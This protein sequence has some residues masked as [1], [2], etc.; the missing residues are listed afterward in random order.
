MSDEKPTVRVVVVDDQ[1]VVR[2]GLVTVLDMFADIDVVGAAANGEQAITLVERH[3]PHVVLMDL[4]MPRSDGVEATAQITRTYPT[5]K[6]VVLT[7][8][9]DDE[10]IVAALRAGALG[11]L[12]K[13]AGREH[14][15]RAIHAA[16][17]GQAVLDPAVQARLVAAAAPSPQH[18]VAYEPLPDGLSP[19][20]GEV[21][22][23]IAAGATNTHI[24]KTLVISPSTVKTHINN[25][26]AKTGV[27][28][29]AQAVTYAYQHRLAGTE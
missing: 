5:T 8:Y 23:L 28:D 4:H 26:F 7:T 3:R 1:R 16:A 24:A 27:T 15:A 18:P 6:V 19:R 10:S 25:I 14:I 20:E 22:A 17:N 9:A 29:R 12:T 21:L 2:E 11:Y 13:D